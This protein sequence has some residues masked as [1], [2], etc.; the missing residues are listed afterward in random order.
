MMNE[1]EASEEPLNAEKEA[2]DKLPEEYFLLKERLKDLFHSKVD[3][4]RNAKGKGKITIPFAGD[5]ELEK[6]MDIFDSIRKD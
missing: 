2:K 5:E 6:I 1:G 4:A 3:L